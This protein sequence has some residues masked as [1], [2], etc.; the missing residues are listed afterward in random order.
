MKTKR[1]TTGFLFSSPSYLSGASTVINLAGNF[2]DYNSSDNEFEA[3]E[4]AIENDF[5]MIGQDIYDVLENK[6]QL[7]ELISK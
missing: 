1:F 6:H 2:Y 5:R 7:K 3:D 4:I